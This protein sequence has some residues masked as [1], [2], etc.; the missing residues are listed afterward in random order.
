MSTGLKPMQHSTR[1]FMRQGGR[2]WPAIVECEVSTSF[3]CE[4]H[5]VHHCCRACARYHCWLA[6]KASTWPQQSQQLHNIRPGE[7]L[8]HVNTS[9]LV[10]EEINIF[11]FLLRNH[12]S[13]LRPKPS[14][15][16]SLAS[17]GL[18]SSSSE[19]WWLLSTEDPLKLEPQDAS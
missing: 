1:I 14:S 4:R 7:S 5:F 16:T 11:I 10:Y 18:K 6:L 9:L 8:Y 17:H 2:C 19:E 15:P 12:S 13:P 3:Y